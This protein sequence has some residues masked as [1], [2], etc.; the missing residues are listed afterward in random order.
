MQNN[1]FQPLLYFYN[2]LHVA[3]RELHEFFGIGCFLCASKGFVSRYSQALVIAFHFN[4]LSTQFIHVLT[5]ALAPCN[6]LNPAHIL[7]TRLA[8]MA[9]D[10][11]SVTAVH[12]FLP[13]QV[14]LYEVLA[15]PAMALLCTVV[16]AVERPGAYLPAG[17]SDNAAAHRQVHFPALAGLF[18]KLVAGRTV[19]QMAVALAGMPARQWLFALVHAGDLHIRGAAPQWR[20]LERLAAGTEDPHPG[21]HLAGLAVAYVAVAQ[22]GVQTALQQFPTGLHAAV[23]VTIGI[24][25][26]KAAVLVALVL[27]AGLLGGAQLVA[28]KL[29]AEVLTLD[30]LACAGAA[31]G[32]RLRGFTGRA[33]TDVADRCAFVTAV[34]QLAAQAVAGRDRVAAGDPRVQKNHV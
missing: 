25:V 1:F 22:T 23:L 9:I 34:K 13:T 6:Y 19:S 8:L 11:A 15:V 30:L 4:A 5:A 32:Y 21:H 7:R 26:A 31:T 27:L 33:C 20:L 16:S 18:H 10:H 29:C 14:W 17:H 2:K 28:Q 24:V 12:L 3:L